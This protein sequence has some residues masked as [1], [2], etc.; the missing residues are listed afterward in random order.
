MARGRGGVEAEDAVAPE[1]RGSRWWRG[2]RSRG[3]GVDGAAEGGVGRGR[4]RGRRTEHSAHGGGGGGGPRG[5]VRRRRRRRAGAVESV[6]GG[7]GDGHGRPEQSVEGAEKKSRASIWG[8][9]RR[10]GN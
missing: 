4:A 8:S 2:G 7:G 1:Q 10:W 5:G 9:N 6:R 3:G